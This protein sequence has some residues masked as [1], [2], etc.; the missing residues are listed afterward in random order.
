MIQLDNEKKQWHV[1]V[2][3][4]ELISEEDKKELLDS[5]G[6]SDNQL[7]KIFIVDPAI[8]ELNAKPGDVIRITRKSELIGENTYYRIVIES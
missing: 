7:P 6:I 1:L 2:P 5:L 8:K 4:H 3:K